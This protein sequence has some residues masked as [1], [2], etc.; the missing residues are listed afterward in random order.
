MSDVQ[1]IYVS[2]RPTVNAPSRHRAGLKFDSGWARVDVVDEP[3]DVIAAKQ[4]AGAYCVSRR[5]A[6]AL[7]DD[8]GLEI[9]N[10]PPPPPP[11]RPAF[12]PTPSSSP[13]S[14]VRV[15]QSRKLILPRTRQFA[16][17]VLRGLIERLADNAPTLVQ[18]L[19]RRFADLLLAE[20]FGDE[21]ARLE[22]GLV[23]QLELETTSTPAPP[24][25]PPPARHHWVTNDHPEHWMTVVAAEIGEV[26]PA[27]V[28]PGPA[29]IEAAQR[30]YLETRARPDDDQPAPMGRTSMAPT[31][32]AKA[33]AEQQLET[34]LEEIRQRRYREV[35]TWSGRMD[36]TRLRVLAAIDNAAKTAPT[37]LARFALGELGRAGR[38]MPLSVALGPQAYL[39]SRDNQRIPAGLHGPDLALQLATSA[40]VR[41]EPPGDDAIAAA[42]TKT[43][44]LLVCTK[45]GIKSRSRAGVTFD[46]TRREYEVDESTARAVLADDGLFAVRINGEPDGAHS[47]LDAA[48]H[49]ARPETPAELPE[50]EDGKTRLRVC[51]KSLPRRARAG[52][53]FTQVPRVVDVDPEA[54]D[55]IRADDALHVDAVE[56]KPQRAQPREPGE[57]RIRSKH[58]NDK[59]VTP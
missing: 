25:L 7:Y 38:F 22:H 3:D 5:G 27:Y 44:R 31:T 53:E 19:M 49:A 13:A 45:G 36:V 4:Q 47:A 10:E 24:P 2:K 40:G 55:L 52:I 51:T 6:D 21:F 26:F 59:G 41:F 37:A 57:P 9:R 20:N 29:E 46:S 50:L 42:T 39:R 34:E 17:P 54:A 30:R 58:K 48:M 35:S 8:D 18:P 14:W 33:A 32:E 1:T 56:M 28:P 12:T 15:A 43:C 23:E 16:E 11:V